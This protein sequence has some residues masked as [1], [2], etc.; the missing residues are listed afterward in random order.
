MGNL[1]SGSDLKIII[2]KYTFWLIMF[3]ILPSQRKTVNARFH[4]DTRY[5]HD[6]YG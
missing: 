3:G 5:T 2:H 6:I 1:L 4:Y